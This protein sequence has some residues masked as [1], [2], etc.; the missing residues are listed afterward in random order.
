MCTGIGRT[1]ALGANRTRRDGGNDVNDPSRPFGD[2]FCCAV[3]QAIPMSRR[4]R[5]AKCGSA[6]AS[7]PSCARPASLCQRESM[8]PSRCSTRRPMRPQTTANYSGTHCS[9][10][11]SEQSFDWPMGLLIQSSKLSKFWPASHCEATGVQSRAS[12]PMKRPR[13]V[14]SSLLALFL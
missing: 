8:L 11:D 7:W 2:Q 9:H 5:R 14:V 1:S 6:G 4:L 12:T 10:S 13:R 3:Q